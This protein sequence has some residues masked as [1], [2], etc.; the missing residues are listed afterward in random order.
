MMPKD[1]PPSAVHEFAR[2]ALAQRAYH[3]RDRG[4]RGGKADGDLA[5]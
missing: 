3:M 5:V 4:E 1:F 2:S